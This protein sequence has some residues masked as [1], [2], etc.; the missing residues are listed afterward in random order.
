MFGAA[1]RVSL[2]NQITT[3]AR[4]PAGQPTQSN[5]KILLPVNGDDGS[6]TTLIDLSSEAKSYSFNDGAELDT[7]Q[8]KWGTASCLFPSGGGAGNRLETSDAA[9]LEAGSNSFCAELWFRYTGAFGAS[10]R[11]LFSKHNNA[12]SN[13]SLRFRLLATKVLRLEL[14]TDGATYQ[15]TIDSLAQSINADAW[16]HMAYTRDASNDIRLFLRGTL[17]QTTN[18]GAVSAH[19]HTQPWGIGAHR[20]SGSDWDSGANGWI[21]DFRWIVGEPLYVVPFIPPIAPHP[22][23]KLEFET[24]SDN[25]LLEDGTNILEIE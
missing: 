1:H 25:L 9:N 16:H 18:I 5:V 8:K 17:L 14:S 6:T 2:G 20:D 15:H 4:I 13:N 24:T 12:G 22:T 19:N 3:P 23:G 21:D 11:T 7:A 10:D